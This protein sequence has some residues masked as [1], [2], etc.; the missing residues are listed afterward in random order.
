MIGGYSIKPLQ[1]SI[2]KK[3]RNMILGIIE[4][5]IETYKQALIGFSLIDTT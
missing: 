1:E 2:F 5:D 4:K 3:F